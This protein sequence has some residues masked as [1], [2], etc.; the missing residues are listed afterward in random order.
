MPGFRTLTW[1]HSGPRI[2]G[3]RTNTRIQDH[4]TDS[5]PSQA[6][7]RTRQAL[8][9]DLGKLDSGLDRLDSGLAS[10]HD[11]GLRTTGFRTIQD[12]S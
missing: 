9:Q 2:P 6:G 1:L 5:G 12:R 8:F 7:F 3:F 10:S 11:S 4:N